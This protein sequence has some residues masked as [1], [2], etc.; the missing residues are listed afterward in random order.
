M[1][2]QEGMVIATIPLLKPFQSATFPLFKNIVDFLNF[3][4]V[5]YVLLMALDYFHVSP[6]LFHL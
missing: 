6:A 2:G 4:Y 3:E 5:E 1:E